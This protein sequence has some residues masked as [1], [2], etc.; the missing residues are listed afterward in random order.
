M[1]SIV[2]MAAVTAGPDTTAFGRGG[3]HGCSGGCYGGG[4]DGR[5]DG[6]CYGGVYG[7]YSMPYGMPMQTPIVVPMQTPIQTP[8][9][10]QGEGAS[11]KF[12][13]P[14][15][16]R[17]FVDGQRTGTTGAERAFVTPALTPGQKYYY[18]VKA[19]LDVGGKTV[20]EEKRVIVEAGA[21][22]VESFPKLTAAAAQPAGVA[23]K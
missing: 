8:T 17:L 14:A 10:K 9:P 1:Y 15:D 7:G 12:Q 22:V 23:G 21:N 16:A 6:G 5:V 18:D 20:T 19:E 13:L 3:C 4:C 11:L 2:L